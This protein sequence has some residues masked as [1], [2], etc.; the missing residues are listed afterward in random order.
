VEL[1]LVAARNVP[2]HICFW[3][4]KLRRKGFTTSLYC[5]GTAKENVTVYYAFVP[6][7]DINGELIALS[8]PRLQ[9]PSNATSSGG[10]GTKERHYQVCQLYNAT[11]DLTLEWDRGFQTITGLFS[12]A[13]IPKKL[14]IKIATIPP[15]GLARLAERKIIL[16][17]SR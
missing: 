5:L 7:F 6:A 1:R 16:Q 15:T 10:N 4:I 14:V 12:A 8:K 17:L 13:R 9:S 11:Y 2:T 3:G